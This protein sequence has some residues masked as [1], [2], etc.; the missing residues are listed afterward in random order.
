MTDLNDL[1]IDQLL[2]L[3]GDSDSNE[4]LIS[5][6]KKSSSRKF[7]IDF[8]ITPGTTKIPNY[9]IFYHYRRSW[10]PY[11][12]K[13][14]KIGFFRDF[15]EFFESGRTNSYRYYLIDNTKEVFDLSDEGIALAKEYDRRY[16]NSIKANSGGRRVRKKKKKQKK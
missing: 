1:T 2:G 14:S 8:K 13:D 5:K 7:T 11:E 16:K 3:L 6:K 9:I 12:V 10:R 15:N 4:S